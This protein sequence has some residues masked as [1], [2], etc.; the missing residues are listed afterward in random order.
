MKFLESVDLRA[1]H[2]Q[3]GCFTDKSK[4]NVLFVV[5]RRRLGV[6]FI[7]GE[8]MAAATDIPLHEADLSASVKDLWFSRILQLIRVNNGASRAQIEAEDGR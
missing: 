5:L 1:L 8:E 4:S 7:R 3:C 6:R 2:R